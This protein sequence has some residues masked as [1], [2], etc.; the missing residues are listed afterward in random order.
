MATIH[1]TNDNFEKEVLQSDVPVFV[2]FWAEWCGPCRMV[3]PA[4]EKLSEEMEGSAKIAKLDVDECRE[5]AIKY[6][7]SSIPTFIVFKNGQIANK[8]MGAMPLARLKELFD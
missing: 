7:V 3:A 5:L 1:L 4:V 8:A 6:G 2:D